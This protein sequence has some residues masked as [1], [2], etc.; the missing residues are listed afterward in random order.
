MVK[1]AIG[2]CSWFSSWFTWSFD[3]MEEQHLKRFKCTHENKEKVLTFAETYFRTLRPEEK[4]SYPEFLSALNREHPNLNLKSKVTFCHHFGGIEQWKRDFGQ[5]L[6]FRSKP[7]THEF[8]KLAEGTFIEVLSSLESARLQSIGFDDLFE[9]ADKRNQDLRL[10]DHNKITLKK[11]FPLDKLKKSASERRAPE[12]REQAP[13]VAT[14]VPADVGDTPAARLDEGPAHAS[15]PAN[16]AP[17]VAARGSKPSAAGEARGEAAV[18][19]PLPAVDISNPFAFTGEYDFRRPVGCIRREGVLL[20]EPPAPESVSYRTADVEGRFDGAD[21]DGSKGASKAAGATTTSS[22][23]PSA[24]DRMAATDEAAAAASRDSA[25]GPGC[26]GS[27]S[28]QQ[29]QATALN[30]PEHP[31]SES[32]EDGKHAAEE[33]DSGDLTAFAPCMRCVE[34]NFRQSIGLHLF[35]L[36]QLFK[37]NH[38]DDLTDAVLCLHILQE[39]KWQARKHKLLLPKLFRMHCEKKIILSHP[40]LSPQGKSS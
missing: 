24:V 3:Q 30:A 9:L 16:E 2:P 1:L 33:R 38:P 40:T 35:P 18:E 28:G 37:R 14:A 27:A 15:K 36:M 13:C 17:Y 22:D 34:N 39:M 6:A 32:M 26:N 8:K 31:A 5:G 7:L 12:A 29:P 21:G 20:Q 11:N 4:G 19:S 23:G 10:N 25:E